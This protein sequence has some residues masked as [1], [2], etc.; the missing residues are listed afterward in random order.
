MQLFYR[1]S[2]IVICL[3]AMTAD[4]LHV[5]MSVLDENIILICTM[6]IR[7]LYEN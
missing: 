1:T 5:T 3:T 7:H 4:V 2:E 6:F